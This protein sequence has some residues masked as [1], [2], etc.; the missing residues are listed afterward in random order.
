MGD[1]KI[2][3]HG[4]NIFLSFLVLALVLVT[5]SP[6]S[7]FA[8]YSFPNTA[9][10]ISNT[11]PDDY[12]PP[13]MVTSGSNVYLTWYDA[14]L[15]DA[16]FA[17]STDGGMTFSAPQDISNDASVLDNPQ[18]A[19]V[20][21]NIYII[22]TDNS[23]GNN[24]IFFS[25]SSNG[26]ST[27]STPGPLSGN[28]DSAGE[29]QI[30]TTGS[31]VYLTWQDTS[32]NPGSKPDIFFDRSI[33][34]GSTF[35]SSLNMSRNA[36]SHSINSAIAISGSN[37]FVVW[38]DDAP[39][40][41]DILYE[42]S[43]DY[44]ATFNLGNMTTP[45]APLNLSN[46]TGNSI[47]PKIAVSGS[48]VYVAWDDFTPGYDAAFFARST[49]GGDLFSSP[50]NLSIDPSVSHGTIPISEK[51]A[52]SGS[53]VYVI[54]P[55]TPPG[56][57]PDVLYQRSTDS[58]ATFD[59]GT[60]STPGA[61]VNL[62]NNSGTSA[63]PEI[64]VSGNNV[65]VVWQDD[66]AGSAGQTNIYTKASDNGGATFGSLNL[67]VPPSE[68]DPGATSAQVDTVGNNE[69]V[70]WRDNACGDNNLA[71]SS[72]VHNLYVGIGTPTTI[73]II[74][75]QSQYK[76]G[77]S[78]TITIDAPSAS[79]STITPTIT[80]TSDTTGITTLAFSQTS[81]GSHVY[82]GTVTFTN[83]STSGSSLHVSAGDTVTVTYSGQSSSA[84][85]YPRTISFNLA[86]YFTGSNIIVTVFDENA[87][88]DPTTIQTV[89]ATLSASSGASTTLNLQETGVDTGTFAGTVSGNFTAYVGD[90]LTASYLGSTATAII[91]SGPNPGGGGGG[92]VRPG[93]VLDALIA[94]IGPA[95]GANVMVPPSF[96]FGYTTSGSQLSDSQ[97]TAMTQSDPFKPVMPS[98][99]SSIDFPFY[100]D[101]K[102]FALSRA[103]NTIETSTEQ[104][105]KPVN[106]KLVLH[107]NE[108]II[109][110]S[111]FTNLRGQARDIKDSDTAIIFDQGKPPSV[112][113][114]HG[115]FSKV[116]V[117]E[118]ENGMRYEFDYNITFAKPM[119]KSDIILRA[120][121][122]QLASA[123]MDI[124]DAWQADSENQTSNTV[125]TPAVPSSIKPVFTVSKATNPDSV[126][127]PIQAAG[128]PDL[129][130]T[131][132]EWGGYS[133][134]SISDSDLL[135]ALGIQAN[136]IPSWFM[137]T[138]KWVVNNQTSQGDFVNTIKYMYN[139]GLVK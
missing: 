80:S 76:I 137:N 33:N 108:P 28:T 8:D 119:E 38:Q 113:D 83:S 66:S 109:H 114:P 74:F 35:G 120:W 13:A 54:W 4:I 45:G 14:V 126:Q 57:K 42:K 127:S 134:T 131:I 48:D 18:L 84:T 122:D 23:N 97:I 128:K 116:N 135:K 6:N 16:M 50:V 79:T 69:V 129:R 112:I 63:S 124:M 91:V 115:F 136:H 12:F 58:G 24:Q 105:S 40:N 60:T 92:L 139:M 49:N 39:G 106:L 3:K 100:I 73:N 65:F 61:P 71:C 101:Q 10:Q 82:T 47:S 130:E 96:L 107:D 53:N 67:L 36:A 121:N 62:S 30:A 11:G 98:T 43:S 46:N 59:G 32:S 64:T 17:V 70:T 138:V 15:S 88:T 111:L 34:S 125:G 20:G 99:D 94:I 9:V 56:G 102:G 51:I 75:D 93:L 132:M 118:S 31:Y 29:P 103:A 37:V 78:A 68:L 44:G 123:D 90:K 5:I 2:H 26:G 81:P 117:T 110:V 27:F 85:I 25:T 72:N 52:A 86:A 7:A 19:V 104:V 77:S 1:C 41:Y 95:E 21:S 87:N 89:M 133:P 55:N 22:W